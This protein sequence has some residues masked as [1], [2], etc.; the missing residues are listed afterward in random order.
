MS[1]SK[2]NSISTSISNNDNT[3]QYSSQA[4]GTN[5]AGI[6]IPVD[7]SISNENNDNN[8]ESNDKK[9]KKSKKKDK[10]EKSKNCLIW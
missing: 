8:K 1:Q 5:I 2:F 3:N 9:D 7:S 6:N 10:K 4:Q